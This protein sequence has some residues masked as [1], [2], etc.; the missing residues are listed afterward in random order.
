MSEA[1]RASGTSRKK[2]QTGAFVV[3]RIML[4]V[5]RFPLKLLL[6]RLADLL[7]HLAEEDWG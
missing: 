7:S 6:H 1:H 4:D 3:G 2:P 5:V